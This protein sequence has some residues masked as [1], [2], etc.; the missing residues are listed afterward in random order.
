[1]TIQEKL[2]SIRL[3]IGA[4]PE[5]FTKMTALEVAQRRVGRA[6]PPAAAP[7]PDPYSTVDPDDLAI[8]TTRL[9]QSAGLVADMALEFQGSDVVGI[10]VIANGREVA[11]FPMQPMQITTHAAALYV[12]ALQKEA[13]T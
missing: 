9:L 7:T 1:M 10:I 11:K 3:E 4:T 13:L 6:A 2:E 8:A 12:A 5:E